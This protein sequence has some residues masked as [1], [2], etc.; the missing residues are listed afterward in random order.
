MKETLKL[1]QNTDNLKKKIQATYAFTLIIFA[2]FVIIVNIASIP[3]TSTA[4]NLSIS[5]SII[6]FVIAGSILSI[7]VYALQNRIEKANDK[8]IKISNYLFNFY[9]AILL[10]LFM[11]SAY[12]LFSLILFL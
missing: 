12:N 5:K 8:Q 6:L 11:L 10:V 1:S 3:I 9:I 2:M 7:P 4:I